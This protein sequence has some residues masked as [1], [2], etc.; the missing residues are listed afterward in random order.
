MKDI[1]FYSKNRIDKF[2][3]KLL[4]IMKTMPF[5]KEFAYYCIDNTP[6]NPNAKKDVMTLFEIKEVPT[7]YVD[8]KK[9]VGPEAFE[10]LQDISMQLQNPQQQQQQHQQQ[11]MYQ[12][13][14]QQ[15][16]QQQPMQR[17]G[18]MNNNDFQQQQPQQQQQ[19][20]QQ[21]QDGLQG[22]SGGGGDSDFANPFDSTSMTISGDNFTAEHLQRGPIDTKKTAENFDNVMEQYTQQYN[23]ELKPLTGGQQNMMGGGGGGG[24]GQQNMMGGFAG[25]RM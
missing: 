6:N 9:Y 20:Q 2:S 24:G 21:Q 8:G 10:W 19:Q 14:Q 23:S 13:Q 22:F 18:P 4:E 7:M 5:A 25:M 17:R 15:Q 12:Q 1:V 3:P 16:Q 11:Q